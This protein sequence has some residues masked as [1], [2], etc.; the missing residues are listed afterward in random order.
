MHTNTSRHISLGRT[1]RVCNR[2]LSYSQ[3]KITFN[4]MVIKYVFH[5]KD[6]EFK[7]SKKFQYYPHKRISI[8]NLGKKIPNY[9]NVQRNTIPRRE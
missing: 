9:R 8:I 5:A 3:H 2:I 6:Y 7:L 4:L 1:L